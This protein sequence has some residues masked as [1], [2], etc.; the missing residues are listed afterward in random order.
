MQAISLSE[1]LGLVRSQAFDVA[2]LFCGSCEGP[3]SMVGK[4]EA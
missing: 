1:L 3:E 4:V 2:G